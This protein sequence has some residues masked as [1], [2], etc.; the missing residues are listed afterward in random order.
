VAVLRF[1]AEKFGLKKTR[2]LSVHSGS[3]KFELY[4]AMNRISKKYAAVIDIAPQKLPPV[5]AVNG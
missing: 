2:R 4:P 5:Q 3:D 1:A